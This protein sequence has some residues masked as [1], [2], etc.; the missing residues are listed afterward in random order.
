[1]VHACY[2]RP[3]VQGDIFKT[4]QIVIVT[5]TEIKS[6]DQVL[7]DLESLRNEGLVE[8]SDAVT[9]TKDDEGK[10]K[11]SET[12]DFTTGRG[13]ATGAALGLIIG[14]VLGGTVGGL[15]LG[16]AEGDLLG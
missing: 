3:L 6:A 13:A 8:L 14:M 7:N 2:E 11:V 9:V 15:V 12:T 1:M 16:T 4:K 5:F 10:L